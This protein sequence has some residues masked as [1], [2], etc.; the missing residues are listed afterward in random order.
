MLTL[1]NVEIVFGY[2]MSWDIIR[3]RGVAECEQR[4][5]GWTLCACHMCPVDSLIF[6]HRLRR[7]LFKTHNQCFITYTRTVCL[8]TTLSM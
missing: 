5:T 7:T 3:V 4:L 8:K 1:C 6:R 2:D